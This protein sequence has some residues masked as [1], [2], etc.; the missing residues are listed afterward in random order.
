MGSF[1]Y[2][3]VDSLTDPRT[4]AVIKKPHTRRWRM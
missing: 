4:S 3:W 2:D 1:C